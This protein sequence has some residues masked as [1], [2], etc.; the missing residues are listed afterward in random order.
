[1]NGPAIDQLLRRRPEPKAH[2]DTSFAGE[3]LHKIR[4]EENAKMPQ[5]GSLLMNM[6]NIFKPL[7]TMPFTA[8]V[9]LATTASVSAVAIGYL[10]QQSF[11]QPAGNDGKISLF[12][13]AGCPDFY[14]LKDNPKSLQEANLSEVKKFVLRP[15]KKDM[16]EEL[17]QKVA[18]AYCEINQLRAYINGNWQDTHQQFNDVALPVVVTSIGA[19][20]LEGRLVAT[21]NSSEA[22]RDVTFTF[23]PDTLWL[24]AGNHIDKANIKQGDVLGIATRRGTEDSKGGASKT[25]AVIKLPLEFS[26]YTPQVQ[27]ALFPLSQ[28]ENNPGEDCIRTNASAGVYPKNTGG[29]YR[30]PAKSQQLQAKITNVAGDSYQLT[31]R[32]GKQFSL[33]LT[34]Y[35]VDFDM[36]LGV[37]DY[38]DIRYDAAKDFSQGSI[39]SI[40]LLAYTTGDKFAPIMNYRD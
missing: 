28:C 9:A 36:K 5:K 37:G 20:T 35:K 16:P 21:D 38:L 24:D 17:Q 18:Q 26:L 25:I 19:N 32:G 11:V 4:L 22:G 27:S 2:L 30:Q 31:S 34:D 15:D 23:Q 14:K 12:Q 13:T 29:G 39:Y 33:T 8:V 6:K 7:R 1:M 40:D 3:T 10:W